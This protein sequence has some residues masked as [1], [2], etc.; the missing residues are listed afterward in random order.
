MAVSL[1]NF[2]I[3]VGIAV[4]LLSI[5]TPIFLG[6]VYIGR[7]SMQVEM[8]RRGNATSLIIPDT[9]PDCTPRTEV[10]SGV[11]VRRYCTAAQ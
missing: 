6:G 11:Q 9:S 8:L 7:L 5:A 2:G 10:Y 3:L 4:G 1:K